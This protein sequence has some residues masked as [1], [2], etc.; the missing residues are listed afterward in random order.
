[1]PPKAPKEPTKAQLSSRLSYSQNTPAFLLRLQNKMAGVS[2]PEDEDE[3]QYEDDEF[4]DFARG[5]GRP[6]IPKRPADSRPALPERPADDPGS[7]D[8]DDGDEAPQV[9]VLKAGKHLTEREA[10]NER[11]KAKGLPPLV[12]SKETDAKPETKDGVPKEPGRAQTQLEKQKN[13]L[14]F[15]SSGSDAKKGK[16]KVAVLQSEDLRD[17]DQSRPEKKQKKKAKLERKALLSFD[18]DA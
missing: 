2:A 4:E 5:S 3:P 17:G 11:R 8:E 14:S 15:N 6:P 7:A 9:V 10:E 12:D 13:S 1:M 18:D 16:R